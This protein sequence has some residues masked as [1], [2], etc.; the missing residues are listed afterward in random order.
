MRKTN[1][2]LDEGSFTDDGGE[3][4]FKVGDKVGEGSAG[5]IFTIDCGEDNSDCNDL[6]KVVVKYYTDNDQVDDEQSHLAKI[7]ELKAVVSNGD[8]HL[9]LMTQWEGSNL[10]QLPKYQ[11]LNEDPEGNKDAINALVDSAVEKTTESGLA[12]LHDHFIF[13]E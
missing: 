13:H 4:K 1:N 9:T 11:E 12:Y 8:D 10:S 5:I 7:D 3:I 6:G 2:N